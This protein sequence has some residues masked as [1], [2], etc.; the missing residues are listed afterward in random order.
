MRSVSSQIVL[1]LSVL[2]LGACAGQENPIALRTI[3]P[4][5]PL[6][7]EMP[8]LAAAARKSGPVTM[9]AAAVAQGVPSKV[10]QRAFEKYDQFVNKVRKPEYITMVDFTQ[11]SRNKR[12]YMVNRDSGKV[13]QWTVAHGSGSDPDNDGIPQYFSNVPDSHMSSLGSYLIQEKYWSD[14]YDSYAIRTDGLESTNDNARARAIVVH[15]AT[16]VEDG[17]NKQGRSWGCPAIPYDW[18]KTV[19]ARAEGGAFMYIYG[20]NK[21]GAINEMR[22]LRNWDLIPKSLWPNESEEAPVDGEP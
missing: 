10:A 3:A 5:S 15:P 14:K 9:Y 7:D 2:I 4:D 1:I 22:A 13:D 11:H 19:I 20:V 18:I 17:S 12:F 6:L 21:R 16:Y 8:A